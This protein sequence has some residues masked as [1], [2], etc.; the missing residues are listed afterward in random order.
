MRPL[1]TGSFL[2]ALA[3]V[4]MAAGAQG[5]ETYTAEQARRGEAAYGLHCAE[6]HHLTL[7]G[8]GH[9][10]ELT[11]PNF[12]ARWG[13]RSI[14]DLLRYN[15]NLMPAGAPN[16][17]GMPIYRDIT[18]YMLQVNGAAPGGEA[19]DERTT[20]VVGAA[21]LGEQWAK[22]KADNA[23]NDADVQ[24]ESWQE[25]GTIADAARGSHGFVNKSI[26]HFTPVTAAMLENPPAGD[27]INWRR[28][29]DA[30]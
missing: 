11:G 9:G 29:Y 17:L 19:L 26:E 3:L 2:A 16:S 4:G 18:A 15:A 12:I 10:S 30:N 13:N 14:A 27:W 6:C 20:T 21:A 22:I 28:T 5:S 23:A 7:R 1:P 25:A 24:W 8:T